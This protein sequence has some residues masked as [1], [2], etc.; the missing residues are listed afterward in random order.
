ME[1]QYKAGALRSGRSQTWSQPRFQPLEP[2]N[3]LNVPG[4]VCMM[5][6]TY[7]HRPLDRSWEN[8]TRCS[9]QGRQRRK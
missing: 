6:G 1:S 4:L 3:S 8:I 7:L 9:R 5:D 2:S